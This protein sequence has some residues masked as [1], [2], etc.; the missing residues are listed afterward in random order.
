M[1][2]IPG[3]SLDSSNGRLVQTLD[4]ERGD[5]IKRG[6]AV[7]ESIISCPGCR[8]ARFP[9]SLALV[10]TTLTPPSCVETMANDGSDVALSRG[11][12]VPVGTVETLHGWWPCPRQTDGLELSLKLYQVC[13]L[14]LG[15]QQSI[16]EAPLWRPSNI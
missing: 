5:F 6:A 2:R 14:R 13:D 16:T 12:A 7:L 9:T 3:D 8:A 15:Y 1:H 11:T 10:A 4:T